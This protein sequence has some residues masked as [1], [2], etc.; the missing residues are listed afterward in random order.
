MLQ[1]PSLAWAGVLA[2]QPPLSGKAVG[3]LKEAWTALD[4][5]GR[6]GPP[7]FSEAWERAYADRDEDEPLEDTMEEFIQWCQANGISVP[8]PLFDAKRWVEA[9]EREDS[10][11][12]YDPY[13]R[14]NSSKN[15]LDR[16]RWGHLMKPEGEV[17]AET[18]DPGL[19]EPE[20][21]LKTL[22]I[23]IGIVEWR[24]ADS[25][26]RNTDPPTLASQE[27]AA[28]EREAEEIIATHGITPS[29]ALHEWMEKRRLK[30]EFDRRRD[31]AEKT[32]ARICEAMNL[33]PD[34]FSGFRSVLRG[35]VHKAPDAPAYAN[36]ADA[37][38][39]CQDHGI[40][41]APK[42]LAAKKRMV[43]E[44]FAGFDRRFVEWDEPVREAA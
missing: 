34:V 11:P 25:L 3:F 23:L 29:P 6:L 8:P 39:Y 36:L 14:M 31:L 33:S 42:I 12:E 15:Q 27:M 26:K 2:T 28:Y 41:V 24:I 16:G 35:L 4:K 44:A 1:Q 10:E 20:K 7:R 38:N 22:E 37:V 30:A 9:Q 32:T 13:S 19:T 18:S 43:D 17:K 40:E 21:R 5:K